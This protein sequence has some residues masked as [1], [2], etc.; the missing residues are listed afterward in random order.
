MSN[1][2][3]KAKILLAED[4]LFLREI[5]Q[6]ILNDEGFSVT[7]A[8]DGEEALT[9]LREGGWDLVLLD[10][11][12]PKKNGLEV[13]QSIAEQERHA[14]AKMIVFLSNMD[15]PAE[16]QKLA[17]VSDAQLLKSNMTPPVLIKRIKGFLGIP[18]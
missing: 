3:T 10:D 4:D 18:K 5:Y 9:H 16:I 2:S 14:L 7:V 8:A 1:A 11:I 17:S 12:M 15:N 6:E 13:L